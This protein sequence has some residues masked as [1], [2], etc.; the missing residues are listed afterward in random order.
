MWPTNEPNTKLAWSADQSIGLCAAKGSRVSWPRNHQK[1]AYPRPQPMQEPY[2]RLSRW[3]STPK[4]TPISNAMPKCNRMMV[5]REKFSVPY[6]ASS[7]KSSPEEAQ[8][9]K[10]NPPNVPAKPPATMARPQLNFGFATLPRSSAH[11]PSAKPAGIPRQSKK[12]TSCGNRSR[13]SCNID[14]EAAAPAISGTMP[15]GNTIHISTAK[16][17]P[18]I[19]PAPGLVARFAKSKAN[20]APNKSPHKIDC[21]SMADNTIPCSA[22]P[23]A[24]MHNPSRISVMRGDNAFIYDSR[25]TASAF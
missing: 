11:K 3:N 12:E 16:A 4:V 15:T 6:P 9:P 20:T 22:P 2:P 8:R 18:H 14:P 21:A 1:I 19:N 25:R 23:T 7:G 10:I 24:P 5:P 17:K 13:V